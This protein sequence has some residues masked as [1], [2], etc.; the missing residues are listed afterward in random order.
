M[1]HLMQ[2]SLPRVAQYFSVARFV[3]VT[4]GPRFNQLVRTQTKFAAA[5]FYFFLAA[6]PRTRYLL[7]A[8]SNY[9]RISA[10]LPYG[11]VGLATNAQLGFFFHKWQAAVS[12]LQHLRLARCS[13]LVFTAPALYQVGGALSWRGWSGSALN[14]ALIRPLLRSATL[15][16]SFLAS[17][18]T[19]SCFLVVGAALN[20]RNRRILA[21]SNVPMLGAT[22]AP[23]EARLF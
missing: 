1:R 11:Q 22:L 4:R 7:A 8:H 20:P 16:D 23:D 2:L 5:T 14:W 6:A 13:F 15:P 21:K 19:T 18:P 3:A 12:L 9:R 10:T 17:L